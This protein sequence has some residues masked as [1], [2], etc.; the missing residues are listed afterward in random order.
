MGA[1]AGPAWLLFW[2]RLLHAN[3]ILLAKLVEGVVGA[4]GF[5]PMTST[6]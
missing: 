5:E 4:I 2:V 1:K 3:R 6:V